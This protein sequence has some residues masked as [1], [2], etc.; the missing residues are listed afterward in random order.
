MDCRIRD[1]RIIHREGSIVSVPSDI[2]GAA[3]RNIRYF[4]TTKKMLYED[5]MAR[6]HWQEDGTTSIVDIDILQLETLIP[7]KQVSNESPHCSKGKFNLHIKP[8]CPLPDSTD[9]EDADGDPDADFQKQALSSNPG[10]IF[11]L[12]YL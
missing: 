4:G 9:D 3:T 10:K 6:V 2:F 8:A 7:K 1:C 12:K 5:T 11:C